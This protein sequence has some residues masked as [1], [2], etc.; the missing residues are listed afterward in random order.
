MPDDSADIRA[1]IDRAQ[2]QAREE[3]TRPDGTVD[4]VKEALTFRR[5][6]MK[7]AELR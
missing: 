7:A 2:A 3:A 1:L 4:G 6:I 5:L